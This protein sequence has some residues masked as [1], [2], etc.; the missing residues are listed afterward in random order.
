[1]AENSRFE[2]IVLLKYTIRRWLKLH[3]P[4]SS[5]F[6]GEGIFVL[7]THPPASHWEE[8]RLFIFRSLAVRGAEGAEQ[9]IPLTH[10]WINKFISDIGMRNKKKVKQ[11]RLSV[12]LSF[13]LLIRFIHHA[14]M[15]Q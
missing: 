9:Q 13:I 12:R 4:I 14:Y 6:P 10:C 1:M 15:S 2:P 5:S 11:F 3:Q 7:F 8:G